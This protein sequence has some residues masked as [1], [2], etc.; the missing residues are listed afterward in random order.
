MKDRSEPRWTARYGSLYEGLL[1]GSVSFNSSYWS[2]ANSGYRLYGAKN[3]SYLLTPSSDSTTGYDGMLLLS[4]Q[5]DGFT[6]DHSKNG[7]TGGAIEEVSFYKNA[8][9]IEI[10]GVYDSGYFEKEENHIVTIPLYGM[11]LSEFLGKLQTKGS[12]SNPENLLKE[13]FIDQ[14]WFGGYSSAGSTVVDSFGG[15]D[16][17]YIDDGVQ[18]VRSG[19]GDDSFEGTPSGAALLDGGRGDD[20]F[21]GSS[22]SSDRTKQYLWV[23]GSGQNKYLGPRLNTIVVVD[24]KSQYQDPDILSYA[25]LLLAKPQYKTGYVVIKTDNPD[26]N[27]LDLRFVDQ[28][29]LDKDGNKLHSAGYFSILYEGVEQIRV[30]PFSGGWDLDGFLAE[31]DTYEDNIRAAIAVASMEQLI[32]PGEYSD[33][34]LQEIKQD[35]NLSSIANRSTVDLTGQTLLDKTNYVSIGDRFYLKEIKQ[36]SSTNQL[37][38]IFNED[39]GT[40]GSA[41][42]YKLDSSGKPVKG[43]YTFSSYPKQVVDGNK[44]ITSISS[45]VGDDEASYIAVLTSGWTNKD[46]IALEGQGGFAT[47][48]VQTYTFSYERDTTRPTIKSISKDAEHVITVEFSEPVFFGNDSS[49]SVAGYLT[50]KKNTTSYSDISYTYK[51]ED[52]QVNGNQVIFKTK[53]P[54]DGDYYFIPTSFKDA[55]ENYLRFDWSDAQLLTFEDPAAAANRVR[56]DLSK[57]NSFIIPANI[58]WRDRSENTGRHDGTSISFS[59][60]LD[61]KGSSTIGGSYKPFQ[62]HSTYLYSFNQSATPIQITIDDFESN[63]VHKLSS[64]TINHGS[65]SRNR[66]DR[67]DTP[68]KINQLLEGWDLP[69][70]SLDLE[71]EGSEGLTFAPE[72]TSLTFNQAEINLDNPDQLITGQA[73]Y[74]V[75]TGSKYYDKSL[76]LNRLNLRYRDERGY[77]LFSLIVDDESLATTESSAVFKLD[78]SLDSYSEAGT[79]TLESAYISW[80]GAQWLSQDLSKD[81]LIKLGVPETLTVSGTYTAPLTQSRKLVDLQID[82]PNVVVEGVEDTARLVTATVEVDQFDPQKQSYLDETVDIDFTNSAWSTANRESGYKLSDL[83]RGSLSDSLAPASYDFNPSTKK[84]LVQFQG[85]IEIKPYQYNGEYVIDSVTLEGQYI[86]GRGQSQTRLAQEDLA[87]YNLPTVVISGA[88]AKSNESFLVLR[89]VDPIITAIPASVNEPLSINLDRAGGSQ[90]VD[91]N[92]YVSEIGSSSNSSS[93]TTMLDGIYENILFG[94]DYPADNQLIGWFLL[95]SPSGYK[96]KLVP[97]NL[98]DKVQPESFWS[99]SYP[100]IAK[101]APTVEFTRADEPGTWRLTHFFQTHPHIRSLSSSPNQFISANTTDSSDGV[102]SAISTEAL[103]SRLGIPPDQLVLEVTNSSFDPT[104]K[105]ADFQVNPVVSDLQLRFGSASIQAGDR[106]TLTVV[107]DSDH[108]FDQDSGKDQFYALHIEFG[109]IGNHVINYDRSD[110]SVFLNSADVSAEVTLGNGQYRTTFDYTFEI[111]ENFYSGQYVVRSVKLNHDIIATSGQSFNPQ[112]E[113]FKAS[114]TNY[115]LESYRPRSTGSRVS[116]ENHRQSIVSAF[117]DSDFDFYQDQFDQFYRSSFS[118][119]QLS[120]Q[121]S[122]TELDD[123][124]LNPQSSPPELAFATKSVDLSS[125]S[126]LVDF[127]VSADYMQALWSSRYIDR[128]FVNASERDSIGNKAYLQIANV[129]TGQT[130][131][132]QEAEL[133]SVASKNGRLT[134]TFTPDEVIPTGSYRIIQITPN[135]FSST[136]GDF[137]LDGISDAESKLLDATFGDSSGIQI[138]NPKATKAIVPSLFLQSLQ[139]VEA[140]EASKPVDPID[141]APPIITSPTQST[142]ATVTLNYTDLSKVLG[143]FGANES[144]T[145]AID[146]RS[147]DFRYFVLDANGVL[148]FKNPADALKKNQFTVDIT[149]R[150]EAGNQSAQSIIIKTG[151]IR[152]DPSGKETFKIHPIKSKKNAALGK[153]QINLFLK[154]RQNIFGTGN[155]LDNGVI[156]NKGNNVL[157]G[158]AG[159]DILSGN[160]GNDT[161]KGGSGNDILRGGNGKDVLIG[162]GGDDTIDGGKGRD[163]L[164]GGAGA[165]TF[166]ASKG[167]DTIYGFKIKAGDVLS[168]FGDTAQLKIRDQGKFCIV[169]GGG[170]KARLKGINAVDLI[171]AM[172]SVLI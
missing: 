141:Q 38:L 135:N 37:E 171:A 113:R 53:T 73:S 12:Y 15:D 39:V 63:G 100:S 108:S 93:A 157:K 118:D 83:W 7:L 143:S 84:A 114:R 102:S 77:D 169:T 150:D 105:R 21:D 55:T 6:G 30:N 148:K 140:S 24:K 51:V 110:F 127:E 120:F 124:F 106:Q 11:S 27:Q 123:S 3:V 1:D 18:Y 61:G 112:F 85:K 59:W 75:E 13:L 116:Y 161:L 89:D 28:P 45:Q 20:V 26:V 43:P 76:R 132:S 46:N 95:E 47:S 2:L 65:G 92:I 80:Q 144:V 165:D 49:T 153:N 25:N 60:E 66:Y 117:T 137:W 109:H 42:I 35:F 64:I 94:D 111:P 129:E 70:G 168:D 146:S 126:P 154:G 9:L 78:P 172:D 62:D 79:Y 170:Y 17:I 40:I 149:A 68:E 58:F 139:F 147:I 48:G 74:F 121:L 166:V 67:Y 91:L 86:N 34:A 41:Q 87:S 90:K 72:F 160:A 4:G 103:A 36:N 130:F 5:Y 50:T 54:P 145:W 56:I 119:S 155:S 131:L 81:Q 162:D 156:G 31:R 128:L 32:V 125:K 164:K 99:G 104:T 115:L 134:Y 29:L 158:L 57:D 8:D 44:V 19:D 14:D 163:K 23:G 82:Q 101:Y 22:G 98:E 138:I 69:K 71:V 151:D 152:I 97:I 33:V 159:N 10:D 167:V 107:L 16:T 122:G 52:V 96:T 142:D 88:V 136:S 133:K